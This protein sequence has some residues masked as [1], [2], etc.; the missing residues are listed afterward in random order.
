MISFIKENGFITDREYAEFTDRAK[1]TRN[2]D[3]RKLIKLGIIVSV[4]KGRATY[5]R[6]K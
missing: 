5:Y 1:S 4:G 2:L 6:L 3:F